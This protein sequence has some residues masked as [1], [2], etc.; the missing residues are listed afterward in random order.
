M[1]IALEVLS[2]AAPLGAECK[3]NTQKHIAL[4]WSA[5]L[6]PARLQTLCSSG[7]FPSARQYE[8]FR[9]KPITSAD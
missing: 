6:F 5:E 4:P 1:F 3:V 9:A 2:Y 8:P 7:A